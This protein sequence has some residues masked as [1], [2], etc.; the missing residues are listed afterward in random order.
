MNKKYKNTFP[1][2]ESWFLEDLFT[3][4]NSKSIQYAVMRNHEPLPFSSGGSD[5]DII[6]HE[7]DRA[8][9]KLVLL[10]TIKAANGVAIGIAHT[11]GFFK[12]IGRAHV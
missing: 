8:E 5:L 6:V 4:L 7:R 12:K 11:I 10:D 9:V 2:S 1:A 3:V